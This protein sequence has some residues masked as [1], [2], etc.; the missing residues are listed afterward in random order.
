MMDNSCQNK[1]TM[2]DCT[3]KVGMEFDMLEAAM[4]WKNYG[5]QMGFSVRK[6]YTNKSKIDGEITSR[7]F[8]CSKEGTRKPDKRD[9]LTSQPR[10][11]TRT[12]CLVR[13]GVSLVRE[14]GKYKVYDFVSEHNHVLHLVATTFMMRPERKISDVQAFAID[15]AY[16][17]GI[18]PKDIHE[19]MSR[20]AGGRANLGYTGI[21]QKN[22]LQTRRQ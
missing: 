10:Q 17:S 22:Y 20:E 6:H 9:H 5:K 14:T 15:V 11:E 12:N 7:R 13:L 4:F 8:L 21:D 2:N 18:K 16:A 1:D 19:L 3:P